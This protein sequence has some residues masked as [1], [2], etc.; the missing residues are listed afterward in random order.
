MPN[1]TFNIAKGHVNEYHNRVNGNDPSGSELV[2]IAV[3]S[4]DTDDAVRD[5]D[6]VAA[7]L[8]LGSTAEAT[9][10]NYARQDLTDTDIAAAGVDDTNNRKDAALPQVTFSS[11]AAGDNWTDIVIAYDATGSGA[12]SALVPLTIHE[13]AVTPNGG[14]III[15]AGDYFRAS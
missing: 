15:N 14:N 3:V 5:V 4:T 11:I 10:T 1:L 7:L 2:V 9:N 6:T 8:A 13:F 12:D